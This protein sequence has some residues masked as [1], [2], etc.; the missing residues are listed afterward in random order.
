M[1]KSRWC[2][3]GE[4][5]TPGIEHRT[6]NIENL[7]AGV[8][9]QERARSFNAGHPKALQHLNAAHHQLSVAL[10]IG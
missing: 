3:Q 6:S 10:S 4:H 9:P 5:R 8:S 2:W 1:N 7:A